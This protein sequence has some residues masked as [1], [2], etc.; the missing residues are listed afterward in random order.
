MLKN[1]RTIQRGIVATVF[2]A[3]GFTGRYIVED[4]ARIGITIILPFRGEEKS[5]RHMKMAGDLGQIVPVRWDSRDPESI[6]RA[7]APANVVI[8]LVS[9]FWETRNFTYE[10]TN[11]H[12]A[13]SI[14]EHSRHCDRFIHVSAAGVDK[15]SESRWARTKAEGEDIVREIVPWATI[16]KPTI[17]FG[18]E[19][20]LLTKYGRMA[21]QYPY[22]PVSNTDAL[23]QPLSALDFGKA[24]V[25]SLGDSD[26]IGQT[27]VLGGPNTYTWD[28]LTRQIVES[29]KRGDKRLPV[30][31]STMQYIAYVS[32][33]TYLMGTEPLMAQEEVKHWANDIVVKPSDN[34]IQSLGVKKP[35]SIDHA[36]IR[37]TRAYR[38][39][40]HVSDL[41]DQA[42]PVH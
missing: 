20:R 17:I 1:T 14:A 42:P 9:R 2:G 7:V 21:L 38:D 13:Q 16:M 15:Q 10:D 22:V 41:V 26:T 24:I 34:N 35:E 30:S 37:V 6:Q 4:L 25:A 40:D 5:F 11:I 36:L 32:Q 18:D 19:D 23:I 31:P 27:Y 33:K 28:E 12:A 8:N 39:P 3:T 29:T